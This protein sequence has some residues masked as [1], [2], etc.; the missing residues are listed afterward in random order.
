MIGGSNCSPTGKLL[1]A[2]RVY[3]AQG[4]PWMRRQ[5]EALQAWER[6]LVCWKCHR[7]PDHEQLALD[8]LPYPVAP[9][10]GRGRWWHRL[11]ALP[12]GNLYAAQGAERGALEKILTREKPAVLLCYFGDIAM[13]VLPVANK[14]G[15]PVVAYLHGDF[16]FASNRWYR[17][18]LLNTL[19]QFKAVVTV[20]EKE[21]DWI[22]GKAPQY[23]NLHVI[24]CGAPTGLFLPSRVRDGTSL[25]CAMASRLSK[26]KGCHI[27]IKAFAMLHAEDPNARLH[28]FGDGPARP[29]LTALVEDL[30]LRAHV[31]FHGYVSEDE[32][33]HR[34][35][36]C[37][38]F[39]Q[40]SLKKEGS[41]V[42]IV[43]AMSCA[44][45]IVATRVGGI[46][47]QVDHGR[48]GFLVEQEDL[49]GMIQ[50]MR[51]LAS[52]ATLRKEFGEAGRQR[53]IQLFD[54]D[55][56]SKRLDEVL[57]SVGTHHSS[58]MGVDLVLSE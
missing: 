3:G 58:N 44:L 41:P 34:L 20:T 39:L 31:I 28:I 11:K 54:S 15:I 37:D 18:S 35:P 26:E 10:D 13:R 9:Y 16:Q 21:R 1:V 43:E 53:A 17:M 29:T 52:S 12:G 38:V 36:A 22:R 46:V 40:H 56:L 32:L 19:D 2:T 8:V 30:G 23:E 7:N 5:V 42:S 24:P 27:S 57:R 14:C 49:S 50:G 33:A 55:R 47:D 25:C 48:T 45:P 4:Q 51:K 6:R